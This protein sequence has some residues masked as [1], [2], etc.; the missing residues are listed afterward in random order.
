MITATLSS[1]LAPAMVVTVSVPVS[2]ST[3]SMSTTVAAGASTALGPFSVKVARLPVP[4]AA[5]LRSIVGASFTG[6]TFSVNVLALW[7]VS[8]PPLAVPPS[9]RTWKVKLA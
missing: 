3:M 1:T 2:K 9:S 7:S 4:A 8:T 5:P 6:A